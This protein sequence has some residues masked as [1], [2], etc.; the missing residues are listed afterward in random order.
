MDRMNALKASEVAAREA[1]WFIDGHLALS[2]LTLVAA[3]KG[4]GKSQFVAHL[5]ACATSDKPFSHEGA[6]RV[7]PPRNVLL[8]SAERS[9]WRHGAP[10]A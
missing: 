8:F 2:D 7:G 1:D 5:A 6:K 9:P 3:P 4:V 10:A